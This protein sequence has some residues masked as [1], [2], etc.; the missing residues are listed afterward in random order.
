[1]GHNIFCLPK[2][3]FTTKIVKI[4][5]SL[6][7]FPW[8]LSKSRKSLSTW[9][10][11]SRVCVVTMQPHACPH[12]FWVLLTS[13]HSPTPSSH[14]CQSNAGST[15][16]FLSSFQWLLF[17]LLDRDFLSLPYSITELPFDA[18]DPKTKM[19]RTVQ[20]RN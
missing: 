16:C 14:W 4:R 11:K 18:I 10:L 17:P 9:G 8:A 7:S 13:T 19:A 1:M 3:Q 2:V 12:V 5:L 20:W 15:L 6:H